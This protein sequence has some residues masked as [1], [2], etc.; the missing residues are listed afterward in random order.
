MSETRQSWSEPADRRAPPPFSAQNVSPCRGSWVTATTGSPW[1][2][3]ATLTQKKGRP[4]HVVAGAVQGVHHPHP[5][6]DLRA[7][8]LETGGLL[9][10]DGVLGVL[11]GQEGLDEVLDVNVGSGDEVAAALDG[12]LLR[13][14]EAPPGEAAA[15][16][17]AAARH[18][19]GGGPGRGDGQV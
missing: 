5:L 16:V 14:A 4:L 19:E 6:F 18:L 13:L 3:S 2:Q 9:R 8:N 10:E 15:L 7:S 11:A 1:W 12:D 17:G